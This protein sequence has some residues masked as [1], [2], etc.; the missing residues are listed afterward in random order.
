MLRKIQYIEVSGDLK[1]RLIARIGGVLDH[2]RD[3]EKACITVYKDGALV[4][5][6]RPRARNFQAAYL[7]NSDLDK[8][9]PEILKELSQ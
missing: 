4:S 2:V 7:H 3:A 6:K 1:D 9:I 8:P 5:N